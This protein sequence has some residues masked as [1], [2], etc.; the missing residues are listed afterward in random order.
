MA[1]RKKS[2]WRADAARREAAKLVKQV[3][4]P[5]FPNETI[6]ARV[7]RAARLLRWSFTRTRDIWHGEARRIDAHEMDQLRAF[8]TRSASENSD[9]D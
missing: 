7:R 8:S 2:C 1:P 3:G 4:E 5:Q 6:K 9:E